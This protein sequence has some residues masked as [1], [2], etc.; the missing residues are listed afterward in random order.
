MRP[1]P[2]AQLFEQ[3]LA[4]PRPTPSLTLLSMKR[5]TVVNWLWSCWGVWG[6]GVERCSS[7]YGQLWAGSGLVGAFAP[8]VHLSAGPS[9]RP[10]EG[11]DLPGRSLG[12]G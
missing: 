10:E 7:L 8:A 1:F 6:L 3:S 12:R 11:R 5:G 4:G 9:V 2:T